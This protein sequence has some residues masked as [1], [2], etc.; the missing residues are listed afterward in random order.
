VSL[1]CHADWSYE[2]DA[3]ISVQGAVSCEGKRG[4]APLSLPNFMETAAELDGEL[5]LAK[6]ASPAWACGV[7][8]CPMSSPLSM[9][10]QKTVSRHPLA[11]PAG[12]LWDEAIEQCYGIAA[13]RGAGSA[14][15]PVE[16]M[17][18]LRDKLKGELVAFHDQL[19]VEPYAGRDLACAE[20][21][22]LWTVDVPLTLFPKRDQGFSRLECIVEI[23][24]EGA[25]G[26][27]RVVKVL[28]DQRAEVVGRVDLGA[29]LDVETNAKLGASMPVS[30]GAKLVGDVAA[31]VYGKAQA[32]F[33]HELRR[34]CVVSEIVGGTGARWRLDDLSH[35]ERVGVEGHLL[36]LIIEAI[37]GA[38]PLHATGFLQAFSDVR[39]L[40]SSLGSAWQSLKGRVRDFFNRGAPLEA[41]GEWRDILPAGPW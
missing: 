28:P 13:N 31:Q 41:Y 38:V 32:E 35:P 15:T 16:R 18:R 23:Q 27:Y 40:T 12:R 8:F 39:W 17:V 22:R 36:K 21:K 10:I 34:E 30:P 3:G 9:E 2:V 11:A 37:P 4:E 25:P 19:C 26:S 20:G 5:R 29:K 33:T 14:E 6:L 1:T 7:G 24:S